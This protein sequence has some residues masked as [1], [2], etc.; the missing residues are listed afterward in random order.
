MTSDSAD[1]LGEI[2][3]RLANVTSGEWAVARGFDWDD[4]NRPVRYVRFSPSSDST[5]MDRDEDAEFIAASP[6][7]VG[8]LLE[9]IEQLQAKLSRVERVLVDKQWELVDGPLPSSLVAAAVDSGDYKILARDV[10]AAL[11]ADDDR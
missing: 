8:W 6:A 5:F 1:R 3:A 10:R 11:G 9:H 7:D 2:K 4:E